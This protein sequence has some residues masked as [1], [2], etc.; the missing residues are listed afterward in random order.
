MTVFINCASEIT[1]SSIYFVML[2]FFGFYRT[3][4][5]IKKKTTT[6]IS[7]KE[8][9]EGGLFNASGLIGKPHEDLNILQATRY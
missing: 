1:K 2:V 8:K 4:S 3:F 7:S 5:E 9:K 6:T